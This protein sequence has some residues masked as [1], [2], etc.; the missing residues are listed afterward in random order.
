MRTERETYR[1]CAEVKKAWKFISAPSSVT[2]TWYFYRDS[3]T[4][5]DLE[6]TNTIKSQKTITFTLFTTL[7]TKGSFVIFYLH[8]ATAEGCIA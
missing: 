7:Y 5:N 2:K 6:Q 4:F 1:C 8:S 3:F